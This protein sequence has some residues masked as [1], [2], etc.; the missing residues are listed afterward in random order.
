MG[1]VSSRVDTLGSGIRF[2]IMWERCGDLIL[3]VC[4]PLRANIMVLLRFHCTDFCVEIWKLEGIKSTNCFWGI[5]SLIFAVSLRLWDRIF[6]ICVDLDADF[7]I[8]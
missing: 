5:P 8:D 6:L 7:K 4:W 3:K 2:S 1:L